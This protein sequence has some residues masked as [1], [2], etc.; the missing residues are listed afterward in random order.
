MGF[1][2]EVNDIIQIS[3]ALI[4]V[5]ADEQIKQHSLVKL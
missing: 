2:L 4:D 5:K 1:L 3:I